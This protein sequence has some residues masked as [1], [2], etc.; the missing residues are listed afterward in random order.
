MMKYFVILLALGLFIS[1]PIDIF[2]E[3]ELK[4]QVN[5]KYMAIELS[6][7]L[8]DNKVNWK[9]P[10]RELSGHLDVGRP[11]PWTLCAELVHPDEQT[12]YL[13][14]TNLDNYNMSDVV[15]HTSLPSDCAFFANPPKIITDPDE[16]IVTGDKP[17]EWIRDCWTFDYSIDFFTDEN[18]YQYTSP[19]HRDYVMCKTAID[20]NLYTTDLEKLGKNLDWNNYAEEITSEYLNNWNFGDYNAF[21]ETL[22]YRTF[23]DSRDTIPP[24][25][26]A[27]VTFQYS[28]NGNLNI[29]DGRF[30]INPLY[31]P[32]LFLEWTNDS[33]ENYSL[34]V[35]FEIKMNQSVYVED[36]ELFFRSVEDTRCPLDVDCVWEGDV[37]V[38]TNIKNQT[39]KMS[40]DFTPGFVF[41][42]VVPYEISLVDIQPHP[43]STEKTDYVATF[44]ISKSEKPVEANYVDF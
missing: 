28:E 11:I 14:V 8:I 39:H 22:E 2:A 21:P 12:F 3:P 6:H 40:V 4:R 32:A 1:F 25:M 19:Q 41:S 38:Q 30:E 20:L 17:H 33:V 10:D 27:T 9:L 31:S 37:T 26:H 43:V 29:F 5:E 16:F 13:S 34:D 24:K 18:S 35:P 44:S 42:Y 15:Y 7:Y 36:L 23:V